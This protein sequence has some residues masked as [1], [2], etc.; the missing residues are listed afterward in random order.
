MN[1]DLQVYQ[2]TE[3]G[4]SPLFSFESWLVAILNY[5]NEVDKRFLNRVERH[6]LTDETFILLGGKAYLLTAGADEFPSEYRLTYMEPNKIYN[7]PKTVWHHI[8]MEKD[9]A[10]AII[11][12]EGTGAA[13]T[14]YFEIAEADKKTVKA[15]ADKLI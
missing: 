7:I 14:D 9:A 1:K 15:L 13:N 4:Y 6:F 2:C 10:I 5:G 12:N 8:L 11:E 3:H